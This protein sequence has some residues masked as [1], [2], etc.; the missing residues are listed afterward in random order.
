MRA[1]IGKLLVAEGTEHVP[2]NQPIATLLTDDDE[3]RHCETGRAC[4]TSIASSS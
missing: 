4:R 2:V 3:R 1:A